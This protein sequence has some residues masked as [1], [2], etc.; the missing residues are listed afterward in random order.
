MGLD[1]D[2]DFPRTGWKWVEVTDAAAT[3]KPFQY[4]SCAYCDQPKIRYVHTLEN[5]DYARGVEVG[6]VCAV[7]LMH[8]DQ[9]AVKFEKEL[10][11]RVD[12]RANF[13]KRGWQVL[14][15]GRMR[16][17]TLD[18]IDVAVF[19]EGDR[20]RPEVDGTKLAVT[21]P[22]VQEAQWKCY[23]DVQDRLSKCRNA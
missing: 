3:L 7:I 14:Q 16:W 11:R 5:D 6:C 19:Q 15:E 8:G 23:D 4:P 18:G 12:R 9:R 21:F 10:R 22:T 17:I 2:P 1:A 13:P 20:Y